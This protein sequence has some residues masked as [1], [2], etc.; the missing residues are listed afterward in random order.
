MPTESIAAE[1]LT[2]LE[3]DGESVATDA[4]STGSE[5]LFSAITT[6]LAEQ[7]PDVLVLSSGEI[8]PLCYSL[9]EGCNVD[10]D[11]GRRPG[12]Q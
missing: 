10:F 6:T 9:A 11:L 1:S 3:I 4:S 2:G 5:Y 12:Y 8:V 7:D